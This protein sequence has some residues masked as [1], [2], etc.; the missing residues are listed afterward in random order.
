MDGSGEA[1]V[2]YG[3]SAPFQLLGDQVVSIQGGSLMIGSLDGKN[4]RKIADDVSDFI[5]TPDL[6]LYQIGTDLY[7]CDLYGRD[8]GSIKDDTY[9][10]FVRDGRIYSMDID[11]R[12]SCLEEDGTWGEILR[13][14]VD[15]Y[16]FSFKVQGDRIVYEDA[17]TMFY[18]DLDTGETKKVQLVDG[19]YS[20]HRIRYVCDE[21][22]TFISFRGTK[23]DGSVVTDIDH[24]SNG[25]WVIDAKT[26]TLRKLSDDVFQ[27][28]YCFG[29]GQ[30]FGVMDQSL[31]QIDTRT[32]ERTQVAG[33]DLQ[34]EIGQVLYPGSSCG[35]GDVE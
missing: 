21:E 12:I 8:S 16:P 32:G 28:L 2:V 4:E 25:L 5:A 20:N 19:P 31:Y 18:V 1:T 22:D 13:I 24:G 17:N 34:H 30:L 3:V 35:T 7:R 14:H 9:R 33:P 15:S 11:G 26:G 23:T 6:I 29:G 10:F 27:E